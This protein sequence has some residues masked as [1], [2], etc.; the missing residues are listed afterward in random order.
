MTF[1]NGIQFR[2]LINED[3]LIKS[4]IEEKKKELEALVDKL[5]EHS[6]KVREWWVENID[7][8]KQILL[9]S[10]GF[11]ERYSCPTIEN[12]YKIVIQNVPV[13]LVGLEVNFEIM[14]TD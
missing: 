12:N 6:K 2:N 10:N 3:V 9:K 7:E 8:H 11:L 4:E 14:E 1:E 5:A 13:S